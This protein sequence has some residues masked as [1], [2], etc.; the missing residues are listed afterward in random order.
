MAFVCRSATLSGYSWGGHYHL[1][2]IVTT[3]RWSEH[4]VH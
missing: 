1:A 3:N 4:T 2:R